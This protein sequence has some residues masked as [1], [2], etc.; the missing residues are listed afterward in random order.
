MEEKKKRALARIAQVDSVEPIE[1]ADRI[2]VTHI[3][4][5]KVVTGKG[6]FK[7]GDLVVYFE[8]D[9]A[10][11]PS[12]KRYEFL[13]ERC[14]RKFTSKSGEVL[15][16]CLR[17]RTIRLR[18]VYSQGLVMPLDKFPEITDNIVHN[19]AVR[20]DVYIGRN[21]D[22]IGQDVTDIL[23]VEHYD[24][25]V[26]ALRPQTGATLAGDAMGLF[27]SDH[28]P[29]TDEERCVAGS[30]LVHTDVGSISIRSIVEKGIGTK[31][32]A[33]NPITGKPEMREIKARS[34]MP[35]SSGW[36]K[37][38]MHDGTILKCTGN[39]KVYLPTLGVYRKV[40]SLKVGDCLLTC[41]Q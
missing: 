40:E 35:A 5:W 18:G 10:L 28:I 38:T 13:R 24:E 15:K 21:P 26:E 2:E 33:Y 6:E 19:E 34:K 3:K 17:I 12:D 14:L 41:T 25:L 39:H 27:P 20:H 32:L 29:K 1:G 31:A 7:P 11:D 23:H 36:Y 22:V 4:G 37:I 16:E 8:I 9:S 30:T